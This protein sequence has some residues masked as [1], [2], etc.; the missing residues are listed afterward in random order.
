[1]MSEAFDFLT[2]GGWLMIPIGISS[3]VA[4]AFFLERIWS[5]QRSKVIPARFLEIVGKLLRER[6]FDEAEALC[7]GN[8]SHIAPI[9]EAGIRYQGRDRSVVKEVMEE[10]G[11][12]EVSYMER[13]VGAVGA[14]ATVAPLLGLLGTVTG[15]I[16]VFQ[17]VVNQTAAGQAADP[18]ALANGIWEALITTAAGLTVAIPSY[19]AY[20]YIMGTID[21]YAV[22]MADVSLRMAEYLVPED[23]APSN[24][25][26]DDSEPRGSAQPTEARATEAAATEAS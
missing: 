1:M 20:R 21:R 19:L 23:Q 17:R 25:F 16:T 14:I 22:E 3:I 12:R 15:M 26:A 11:Q 5:L 10:I 9:L 24:R 13:F 4:L 7:H 6:R 18:G 8:D 2:K